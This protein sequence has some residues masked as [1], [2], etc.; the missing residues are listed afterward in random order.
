MHTAPM[1]NVDKQ[2]REEEHEHIDRYYKSDFL[3]DQ[4]L[5]PAAGKLGVLG[6]PR[7]TVRGG[8][9]LFPYVIHKWFCRGVDENSIGPSGSHHRQLP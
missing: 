5:S 9:I 7:M 2:G 4:S 1:E 8:A 3:L 6:Q